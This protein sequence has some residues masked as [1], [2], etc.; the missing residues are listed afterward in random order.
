VLPLGCDLRKHVWSSIRP[1]RKRSG[2]SIGAIWR[3]GCVWLFNY[4]LDRDGMVSKPRSSRSGARPKGSSFSR[5]ALYAVLSNP[6][7]IGSAIARPLSG[8]APGHH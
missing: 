6:L 8:A 5:G 2:R 7:Y 3:L 1:K 4:G